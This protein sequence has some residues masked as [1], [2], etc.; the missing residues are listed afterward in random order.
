MKL[1]GRAVIRRV[2]A[3]TVK[4]AEASHQASDSALRSEIEQLRRNEEELTTRLAAVEAE[5]AASR[6][7][8]ADYLAQIAELKSKNQASQ[9]L[10]TS[11]QNSPTL[12]RLATCSV[13]GCAGSFSDLLQLLHRQFIGHCMPRGCHAINVCSL[14]H[15]QRS[16]DAAAQFKKWL[17]ALSDH[18]RN[19][20]GAKAALTTAEATVKA[21]PP[22][23]PLQPLCYSL[24]DSG[25]TFHTGRSRWQAHA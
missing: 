8:K 20:L 2:G 23:V 16:E 15:L 19:L 17:K 13:R 5:L 25:S 4:L 14:V 24:T 22:P 9:A 11:L 1:P 3:G 7:S 10:H 12:V 6:G 21:S 18:S